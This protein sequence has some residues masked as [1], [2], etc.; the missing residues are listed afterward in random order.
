MQGS[1]YLRDD[2]RDSLPVADASQKNNN[3]V[4]DLFYLCGY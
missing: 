1:G 4:F 3:L 2:R